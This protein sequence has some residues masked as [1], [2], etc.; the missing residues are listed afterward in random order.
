MKFILFFLAETHSE[1]DPTKGT[2]NNVCEDLFKDAFI[3]VSHKFNGFCVGWSTRSFFPA[4]PANAGT[5][6]TSLGN[7]PPS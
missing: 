5:L 4:P 1:P 7:A 3:K 6:I 2:T